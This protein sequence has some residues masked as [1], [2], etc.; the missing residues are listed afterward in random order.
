MHMGMPSTITLNY[1]TNM[2]LLHD[3]IAKHLQRGLQQVHHAG[4]HG[5]DSSFLPAIHNLGMEGYFIL[6]STWYDFLRDNK[7]VLEDFIWHADEAE[8]SANKYGE[9]CEQLLHLL[10]EVT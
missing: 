3:I 10:R 5:T 9:V 7:N 8:T 1:E 2:A 6:A 4:A